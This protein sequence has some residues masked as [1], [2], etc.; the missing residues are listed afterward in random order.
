MF[1]DRDGGL[2]EVAGGPAGSVGIDVVVVGHVLAVQL[3]RARQAAGRITG[4][5]EGCRLVR[6]FSIPKSR[7]LLPGTSDPAREAGAR[8][9]I[10]YNATHPARYRHV[11][12][13]CVH[14]GRRRQRF[15]LRQ[16]EAAGSYSLQQ[17]R[18]L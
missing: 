16:G 11:I 8:A 5:I 1:D 14:E 3:L 7:D 4:A 18:I 9:E 13:S 17:L 15:P 2:V 12:A 6:V 10:T